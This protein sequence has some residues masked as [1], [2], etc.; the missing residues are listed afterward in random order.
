MEGKEEK[1]G[2]VK[3]RK[4]SFKHTSVRVRFQP[5]LFHSKFFEAI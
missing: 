1:K 2:P 5:P 4:D 3:V